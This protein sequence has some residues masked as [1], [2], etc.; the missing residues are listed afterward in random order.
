MGT[1][2]SARDAIRSPETAASVIHAIIIDKY[3]QEAYDWDPSTIVLELQD[4]YGAEIHEH[5]LNR[6]SAIQTV[7][8]S[9]V[10][11]TRLDAFMAVCNTLATGEPYF[12]VFDPVTTEE[13]A[14]GIAEISLNRELLPFGRNIKKYL[15]IVM[16]ADGIDKPEG[17]LAAAMEDDSVRSELD[18]RRNK[19]N[20]ADF[21]DQQLRA[22]AEQLQRLPDVK[23]LNTLL[24]DESTL[25]EDLI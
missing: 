4:D 17:V 15:A 19:D 1:E 25:V 23:N 18:N 10:V 24:A 3:G 20:I 7:M 11:F 9:D 22:V 12:G 13:A 2:Y 5:T 6:W 14:W 16:A 8:T 21:V